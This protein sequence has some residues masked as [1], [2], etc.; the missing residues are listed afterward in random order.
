MTRP[1]EIRYEQA[2]Y[3]SFPFWD[4]GYAIL[5]HSPGC[6]PEWLVSLRAACQHFGERPP[7]ASEANA[8]FALK[9][10]AGPWLI[11]GV[12]P[13]G[14]DDRGRP[15]ALAFHALFLAPDDYRRAGGNPFDFAS[16][17]RNDWTAETQTLPTGIGLV[18]PAEP[19]P[20]PAGSQAESIAA[21]LGRGGRVALQ[22]PA[23]IDALARQVWSLL[24]L[25]VRG[26]A[27]VATWA[28][29]NGNQFDLVALPR[30]TG[31]EFDASYVDLTRFDAT[32]GKVPANHHQTGRG[33][34][35]LK[36]AMPILGLAALLL[37][38]ALGIVLRPE[39]HEAA[40]MT[41]GPATASLAGTAPDASSYQAEATSPDEMNRVA[42]GLVI[43][44]EQFGIKVAGDPAS[45]DPAALMTTLADRLRYRG[46]WLSSAEL[47]ELQDES[48][49][50]SSRDRG[51]A[52]EWH[53]QTRR[54]APDRAL[55]A[56]FQN[57]PLRWQLDTL[58]WSFHLDDESTAL[59]RSPAEI[60]HALAHALAVD[61]SLRETPLVANHPALADYR[62]FLSRIPRR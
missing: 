36:R 4:R 26:R 11:V 25:S 47:A 5:A 37:G 14:E 62:K 45:Q 22:T 44:A 54:F 15:G 29:G 32:P 9:L 18:E 59:R 16:F 34:T 23:P 38:A 1:V 53:M 33:I 52:L 8:L 42:E 7:G 58:A 30:L 61:F 50:G 17:L 31:V 13:Q 10:D 51:L 46:P 20:P 6:Q 19:S 3:G 56:G 40:P 35:L 28:F 12:N 39:H 27:S 2:V 55:P 49:P 48:A 43:L 60:P 41:D 57:G 24:P 21:I